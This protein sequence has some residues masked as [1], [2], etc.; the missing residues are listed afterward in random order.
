[1]SEQTL[2]DLFGQYIQASGIFIA[3]VSVYAFFRLEKIKDLLIGQGKAV[4]KSQTEIKNGKIESPQL[5]E[6]PEIPELCD[7]YYRRLRGSID[8]NNIYGVE[9]GLIRIAIK[10]TKTNNKTIHGYCKHILPKF[11]ETK[12]YKKGIK[13]LSMWVIS[14]FAL[15]I[16]LCFFSIRATEYGYHYYDIDAITLFYIVSSFFVVSLFMT[17]YLIFKSNFQLVGFENVTKEECCK[18]KNENPEIKEL[19]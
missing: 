19:Y 9:E 18:L 5:P 4:F 10:E 15:T 6:L 1:M 2:I 17:A 16:I 11:I 7:K 3:L 12:N 8:R 13:C 14:L